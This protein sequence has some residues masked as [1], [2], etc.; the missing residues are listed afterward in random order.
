MINFRKASMAHLRIFLNIIALIIG[1]WAAVTAHQIRRSYRYSL[2]EPLV[3]YLVCL[4]VI[5]FNDL[6]DWYLMTN[7]YSEPGSYESSF[8]A[9]VAFPIGFSLFVIYS[10]YH[11]HLA[12]DL[13]GKRIKKLLYT[14]CWI[15]LLCGIP[16]ILYSA[17][18][19]DTYLA[20]GIH[21]FINA[22]I[23]VVLL[24][25]IFMLIQVFIAGRRCEE[26]DFRRMAVMYA[27]FY[28]LGF[29]YPL[30]FGLG[31][32]YT[33]IR[34]ISTAALHVV[35]AVFP[36]AWLRFGF[37]PYHR[38]CVEKEQ[39]KGWLDRKW[40][41]YGISRRER[42]IAELVLR[43][44]KNR[45]IERKLIISPHTVKN[46]IYHIYKKAGVTSRAQFVR[47]MLAHES[48]SKN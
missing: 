44:M 28:L 33:D 29:I 11:L 31:N 42:D 38:H 21:W 8:Y 4:N 9:I 45:E 30:L 15:M 48:D 12:N 3:G 14:G 16:L 2:L 7:L 22:T 43:G 17:M 20:K 27:S 41:L 40:D 26:S 5:I 39:T 46:H 13:A 1:T 6:V 23:G 37:M 25:R 32:T 10:T 24:I 19:S 34:V 36:F 35:F 47:L 18:Q